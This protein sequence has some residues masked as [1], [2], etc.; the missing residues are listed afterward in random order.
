VL[1]SPKNSK[2]FQRYVD[3]LAYRSSQI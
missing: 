1:A 3:Y 2:Q